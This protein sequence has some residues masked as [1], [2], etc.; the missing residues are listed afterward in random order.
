[1]KFNLNI[2]KILFLITVTLFLSSCGNDENKESDE[3]EEVISTGNVEDEEI[4][5]PIIIEEF[6]PKKWNQGN[7]YY[8]IYES[9]YPEEN[10]IWRK[11]TLPNHDL[12]IEKLCNLDTD[13]WMSSIKSVFTNSW[14]NYSNL[15]FKEINDEGDKSIS[16]ERSEVKNSLKNINIMMDLTFTNSDKTKE[17]E[18]IEKRKEY[19]EKIFIDWKIWDYIFK[20]LEQISL[21]YIWSYN[22]EV[23]GKKETTFEYDFHDKTITTIN[24]YCK[25]K[26]KFFYTFENKKSKNNLNNWI[27]IASD[28]NNL[29]VEKYKEKKWSRGT[30][31]I[32]S[33]IQNENFL[34]DGW[35]INV[36][37]SDMV[38]TL[39]P[40]NKEQYPNCWPFT[41]WNIK[42]AID[43]DCYKNQIPTEIAAN[44]CKNWEKLFIYGI[45]NDWKSATELELMKEYYSKIFFKNCNPEI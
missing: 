32:E 27:N 33:L 1:M 42:D 44:K 4:K 13:N 3:P 14:Y 34:N 45:T 8:N 17:E 31:L 21:Y 22:Y 20:W 15:I 11:S 39:N 12:N 41:I 9:I 40:K 25:W 35:S 6:I 5:I 30:Y 23:I 2:V 36:I 28:I 43:S 10:E 29:Y 16:Y 7:K 18:T 38:W 19:I 26:D 37:I 24:Y